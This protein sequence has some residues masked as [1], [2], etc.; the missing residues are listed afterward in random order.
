M[1]LTA[2]P[3]TLP[4]EVAEVRSG[5]VDGDGQAELVFASRLD[6][7]A[8]PA[9]IRLTVVH[10]GA[11]GMVE[12]TEVVDLGQEPWLWDVEDGLW[13]VNGVGAFRL[14]PSAVNL[15]EV[16][17]PLA[18][19]G[20]ASALH[21]ELAKDID[22]DG[23]P[24]LL[25]PDGRYLH[26]LGVE[27]TSLG[28][29]PLPR[30]GALQARWERGGLQVHAAVGLLPPLAVGD[31]DGDGD[32]E[33]ILPEGTRAQV[34]WTEGEAGAR[35]SPIGLPVD[36]APPTR[37]D[38]A[39]RTEVAGVWF[40]DLDGDGR[41]DLAVHRRK[42][43]RTFF[44]TTS[45]LLFCRGTGA[46]F[47]PPQTVGVDK[48]SFGMEL[49]DIDDDGDRDVVA[50]VADV[51]FTNVTRAL[52]AREALVDVVLFRM[53]GGQLNATPK[54]LRSMAFPIGGDRT[55][56][57]ELREDVTGDGLPDLVTNDGKQQV[58]VYAGI[59]HGFAASPTG[60]LPMPLPN[61]DEL[62]YVADLTGDGR[63]EIV[64]W[65]PQQKAGSVVSWR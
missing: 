13:G 2:A 4:P 8:E 44:G 53:E 41:L 36:L 19:L 37:S 26:V 42:L 17:T 45:E 12:R 64:V 10:I 62:F 3:L 38:A 27:G 22:G 55:L 43:T 9:A 16:S 28:R 50:I 46:G 52:V 54:T 32:G 20:K 34:H 1:P 39:L 5:D 48:A 63:A 59:G 7:G 18:L 58:A 23:V 60:V 40:D 6:R 47:G 14:L 15:A 25:V 56:D 24:E 49:V 35:S 33:L 65:G 11:S 30:H 31:L 51:G 57:F 29:V 21:A 61:T